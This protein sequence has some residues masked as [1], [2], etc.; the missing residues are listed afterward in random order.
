VG[1]PSDPAAGEWIINEI[2]FN[3][4]ANGY[5]YVEFYNNSTRILDASKLYIANRNSS[6]VAGSVKTL[7][8]IPSYIFPGGYI[9]VTEDA[10]N[11]ALNYL[12][13]DP[14]NVLV[15]SSLPSFPDDE[16]TVVALNFQGTVTDEVTYR[17]DWH[18]KLI[19]NAEGVSLE[20]ID[21]AGPSQQAS[22]WHS[23]ASTAG[24][25]TPG[26][27]NSQ[28]RQS[29]VLLLPLQCRQKHFLPTMMGLMIS[30]LFNTLLT[31]PAM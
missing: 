23:A 26:Y 20:R 21:P 17:D 7:S 29:P 14:G 2:L 4:R 16:G 5:D 25:G 27:K 13:K 22:N 1:L 15:I 24:Y 10:D 9:V 8:A 28:Y 12:V 11:L 18:F 31:H 3:P 19:D 6:G 30:P